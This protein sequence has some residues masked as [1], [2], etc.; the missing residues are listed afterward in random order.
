MLLAASANIAS[1]LMPAPACAKQQAAFSTTTL[2][3]ISDLFNNN[4]EKEYAGPPIGFESTVRD[5]KK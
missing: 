4:S 3:E 5:H 2:R 1:I